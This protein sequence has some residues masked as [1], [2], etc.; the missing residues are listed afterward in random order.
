MENPAV[1]LGLI[2]LIV[3]FGFKVA[4]APFHMW[5][6]D[7]YEGAPTSV[8]AFMSVGPKAAGFAVMAGS[9]LKPLEDAGPVEQHFDAA[10]SYYNG[11]G[12]YNGTC[13]DKYKKDACLQFNS[14][15]RIHAAWIIAGTPEGLASTVTYLMIYMFMNIGAFAIVIMLR[16]E[17]F[18]VK[19]LMITWD[20]QKITRLLLR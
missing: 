18:Q 4:L 5:A 15:C 3:A 12:K 13:T 2:F 10:C 14:A 11:C 20:L 16:R 6:P 9:Y 1:F 8:T 17:G 7:V 19:T